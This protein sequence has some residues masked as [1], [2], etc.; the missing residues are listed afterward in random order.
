MHHLTAND[1]RKYIDSVGL[2]KLQIEM[3]T[4]MMMMQMRSDGWIFNGVFAL[5]FA[6]IE[7]F[8]SY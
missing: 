2:Q 5:L 4:E 3:T 6:L 8:F 1:E 7:F